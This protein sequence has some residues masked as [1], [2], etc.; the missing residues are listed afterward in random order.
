MTTRFV[1]VAGFVDRPTKDGRVLRRLPKGTS[2]TSDWH[3]PLPLMVRTRSSSTMW[4]EPMGRIDHVGMMG[5]MIV[6]SGIILEDWRDRPETEHLRS[7][8]RVL[9]LD[10]DRI[11]WDSTEPTVLEDQNIPMVFTAWRVRAATV[12][13]EPA[14]DGL[15]TMVWTE[16]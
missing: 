14:W 6:L 10:V 7:G 3:V 16:D 13:D 9:G 11:S 2:L 4:K 5:D 8:E 12:H 15:S 1:S